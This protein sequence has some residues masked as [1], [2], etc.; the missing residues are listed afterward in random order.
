MVNRLRE[1]VDKLQQRRITLL[2]T[3]REQRDRVGRVEID[4][5]EA[6]L[7]PE[8]LN[9][10]AILRM[11]RQQ[12]RTDTWRNEPATD[13][14]RTTLATMLERR[15]M[16]R[17]LLDAP[18][19][20]GDA[21]RAIKAALDGQQPALTFP[22][23]E[24][25][26][27]FVVPA[28]NMDPEPAAASEQAAPGEDPRQAVIAAVVERATADAG[29][30]DAASAQSNTFDHYIGWAVK[31]S[32][33]H[34]LSA[35]A[36]LMDEGD[37]QLRTAAR[38]LLAD[39]ALWS[40]VPRQI[41]EEVWNTHRGGP[42]PDETAAQELAEAIID[43][44]E[45]G[46]V[47]P[48]EQAQLA[49]DLADELGQRDEPDRQT[50]AQEALDLANT[51]ETANWGELGRGAF[52][53]EHLLETADPTSHP[54]VA[55]ALVG[56]RS[57]SK[58]AQQIRQDFDRGF[59][60][61]RAEYLE[62]EMQR[63][64]AE[65]AADP[66]VVSMVRD[67]GFGALQLWADHGF[68][69]LVKRKFAD[70]PATSD[71]RAAA[72]TE[73]NA[74]FYYRR[75]YELAQQAVHH[76]P[77][78][79]DSPFATDVAQEQWRTWAAGRLEADPIISS[80]FGRPVSY[81]H[82][83]ALEQATARLVSDFLEQ[84]PDLVGAM[85]SVDTRWLTA[86][87]HQVIHTGF[88]EP[89]EH[90]VWRDTG[91]GSGWVIERPGKRRIQ[92]SWR[93]GQWELST[94]SGAGWIRYGTDY[95]AAQGAAEKI[96]GVDSHPAIRAIADAAQST[97]DEFA[98]RL[99]NALAGDEFIDAIARSDHMCEY[100]FNAVHNSLTGEAV[101]RALAGIA[102]DAPALLETAK[103]QGLDPRDFLYEDAVPRIIRAAR[104]EHTGTTERNLFS[105]EAVPDL[106][107]PTSHTMI[108]GD[109]D[110]AHV[111]IRLPIGDNG[112][113]LPDQDFGLPTAA[114]AITEARARLANA[115][116]PARAV[117][118]EQQRSS[119]AQAA[120]P[121]EPTS[122]EDVLAEEPG[123]QDTPTTDLSRDVEKPVE[124]MVGPVRN[125]DGSITWAI[126]KQDAVQTNGDEG[127]ARAEGATAAAREAT[128]RLEPRSEAAPVA[129][130]A[131]S[132]PHREGS[133]PQRS[134]APPAR[135]PDPDSPP[136][137]LPKVPQ[138][139]MGAPLSTWA[140]KRLIEV[141]RPDG[142]RV[143]VTAETLAQ[144][145]QPVA[146][147]AVRDIDTPPV[148]APTLIAPETIVAEPRAPAR[149]V[150]AVDFE[151]GT[152]VLVPASA[153]ARIEAN[154]DA[155]RVVKTLD[156]ERRNAT[157]D[158]QQILARWSGWGGAWQVFDKQKSEYD[159]QRAEL[160][161]LL[162]DK[163]F[164]A[165]RRSTVNAH[166]TDPALVDAMWDALRQAGLPEQARVLEPGCGAGH[167]IS[168]APQGVRMV[169]V[170]LDTMTSKI[171]HHLY[172]SQHVRNHGFE[173][174]F[175]AD[176]SFT[177]AIGNVPFGDIQPYDDKHNPNALS[178]HNYFIRKSLALTQP[179]GYVATITSKFTSDAQRT[180]AREQIAELGDFVG[181][182]RLPSK[183]FDRQAKTDVVTDLLI[184]R[185]REVGGEPTE[186]TKQW[187]KST[188]MKV[189]DGRIPI[190]DYF[191]AHPQNVL[192]TIRIGHGLHGSESLNVDADTSRPLVDQVR[193]RLSRITAEARAT[194]LGLTAPD[195]D[196]AAAVDL[197]RGGLF[198]AD[199]AAARVIPGTI[200]FNDVGSTFE[201]YEAGR[202]TEL[203]SKGKSRTA[204]WRALLGMGDTVLELVN[205][206][207]TATKFEQ[208]EELRERLNRQYDAYV[209][210][211][212][213]INR[214]KWTNHATRATDEQA[215]KRFPELERK[216]RAENGDTALDVDG[217]TIT[218][219][220]DGELP[221]EVVGE[222][223]EVAYIPAQAPYKKRSHLEGAIKY[224]PRLAMVRGIEH[225]NDD[226]HA[227]SKAAIFHDDISTSLA[228]ATS[229]QDIDEA[230][231]ISLDEAGSIDP[232]RMA[233]LLDTT[234]DD[235]LG[236]ARGKMYPAIESDDGWVPAAVFL[237]GNVRQKLA[238]ARVREAEN[239]ARYVDAVQDLSK[240]VPV[241]VDPSKI[242]LRPG[243]AWIGEDVYRQFLVQEFSLND[244]QLET[245]YSALTGSWNIRSHQQPMWLDEQYGYRDNWGMPE[246]DMS[247]IKLFAAMCNNKPLQCRKTPEELEA[248]PKP[249]FH[250]GRT[251]ELRDRA[252]RLEERF[253]QWLWSDPERTDR[254]TRKFN[255]TF[256]S[257]VRLEHSTEHKKF[258]GLNTEKYDP[259]PYQKQAVVRL[260]HDETVLLDHCVG[261][262]KTLSIAMSCMEMKRLGL[263]QQPW[264]V[265]PNHLVNQW[266]R[267]VL[268]AYP[269]ANVLVATDLTGKA[270][271]QRFMGQCAA[272]DWDVVIVP[273][274]KFFLMAVSPETQIDYIET[275]KT[276]LAI[277]LDNAKKAGRG[278]TVKEIEK[279]LE[280][281]EDQLEKLIKSKS[282]DTGITFEQT[283]C[284]FMFV[285]EAHMYKNLARASNSSDLA[286]IKA[287]ERASDMDM[288]I[289]YLRQRA[290]GRNREAGR[291]NAPARAAAFATG[292]PVSNSMSELWVMQK[293]LRPDLLDDLQ[294]GHIDAWA[295][296]FARQRTTVEMNVTGS[297]LRPVSR[298]AEYTNLPQLIALT[299]Q[300]RD[301]VVRDQ[302]PR[303][304][305]SLRDGTRT[306]VNFT[307]GREVRD[308]MHDLDERMQKTTRDA[309]HLDNA[310]KI[311]NDG[312]N[313]SLH[314]ALANLAEPDPSNDRVQQVVDQVW[315]I[316]VENA[317]MQ[318]PADEAG[319]DAEGVFQMVFCDRGT[320]KP[321]KSARAG[322]LYAMIRER[323]VERGMQPDEI[324]FIHDF[325]AAKD[326]QRLFADCRAGKVRVLIGSTE[327]MSTGVNAQRLLKA[328]HHM[329]CPYR[330]A[331]LEQR[332]GRIIRQGNVHEEVEILTYVAEQSFDA[333]MWQI[334][335]RKAHYIQQLKT[336][337]VPHSMEDIGGE[338]AM[339]AA[340]TKAAATGDPVYVEAVELESQVKRL[341]NE[342]R[343]VNQINHLNEYMIRTFERDLPIYRQQVEELRAIAGPINEWFDTDRERRKI[344]IGSET[345]VDGD[346]EKV[347]AAL[348]ATLQDRYTYMR[349]NKSEATETLFEVAGTPVYGTYHVQTGALRLHTDG[350]LTRYVEEKDALD[351]MASNKAGHGLMA[352]VRNMLKTVDGGL[353]HAERD[354][355]EMTSRLDALRA[356][357][358][359]EFTKGAELR[360]L[361]YDLVEM[362]ADINAR[363]NSPEA[364]R[365]FAEESDR[366]GRMGLYPGWSLDLNPT[367]GHADDRG[368]TRNGLIESVPMRM[369]S[370]ADRWIENEAA[371]AE[372]RKSDPWQ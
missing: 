210:T 209:G 314:P 266:H 198:T 311:S 335:E 37:P 297:Q 64:V 238:Q 195:V 82:D 105:V 262:G 323:L 68:R 217:E 219:P 28:R 365:R 289:N 227:V 49:I 141:E 164:A 223:W 122:R 310:L 65:V 357:P 62:P 22:S 33:S 172:P 177:A 303:K 207:R 188:P 291:P 29:L 23:G 316:H 94:N 167:F 92:I 247:G 243:A 318:T 190:N 57:N 1:S 4:L 309:M 235:V 80:F 163:E 274:S 230:I 130:P 6:G 99:V 156:E 76:A 48:T 181:G 108:V 101:D 349:M 100:E 279:A 121:D 138:S 168:H 136:A 43:R 257:F 115:P 336:G 42:S 119:T 112:W 107:M 331:D 11:G 60:A 91:G 179:G 59:S 367:V 160:H 8:T 202:W 283:G 294:M 231:A 149:D 196:F 293:Y 228:P 239:P 216:W 169:G 186:Q 83:A 191:Q 308:F 236:Q 47:T 142:S 7:D 175:A 369:Q 19:T 286:V 110:G 359:L 229:A 16:P 20:K 203:P 278:H 9:A 145:H 124:A 45:P 226:T 174:D 275:E 347:I 72:A 129:E 361:E 234:V 114:E 135:E 102:V 214:Y 54:Q 71:L 251:E 133:T 13:K 337:D 259:F 180:A 173:R 237:S 222:L 339:S 109:I 348:Q 333:T 208:R 53:P 287:A 329:D 79:V 292:T 355:L 162:S 215:T 371:R 131:P 194:G 66:D 250:K 362:K 97:R 139:E 192:G 273:E 116:S 254:L 305:P 284:D 134:A 21:D 206:S 322:N 342:E 50:I 24:V 244:E 352:R 35:L 127:E 77:A 151:L 211:Y 31:E 285:D 201:Q 126:P 319:P 212:G 30:N 350:G 90:P 153:R 341:V 253:T 34:A 55:A 93:M 3:Y 118:D 137:E 295:Q 75:P 372:S 277:G 298:M 84:R 147:A 165:A 260:L 282:A 2:D 36:D 52:D 261:A 344:T 146:A 327:T 324:A 340:Q 152:A 159:A 125:P 281:R 288:K 86:D 356:E 106:H 40:E 366:R 5:R 73:L 328:L 204:E 232:R 321:G 182:V 271:R 103:Q 326:K 218:E 301:V 81:P 265:V 360:R 85:R 353:M 255:D 17:E 199:N 41:A 338:M 269:G 280:R 144:Y 143:R 334:V 315:R 200:R 242:G 306:I 123:E 264:I 363:E 246:A 224:D 302:I 241:D 317:D 25:Q 161:G 187:I 58:V 267:E 252:E 78:G 258:P 304:L 185:R 158:E 171:A 111:K 240:V 370:H 157:P 63:V 225:Y 330:P 354:L 343:S 345:V 351:A 178:I 61:A 88:S 189:G 10:R 26:R 312:R 170:E 38:I 12:A 70:M 128:R 233:E 96:A 140:S 104:A 166:Y 221:D 155:I 32:K 270:D 205:A 368:L 44:R 307:L 56:I 213:P 89:Q 299:D 358:P 276:A 332:E 290:I 176:A 268:D 320:P 74:E 183:A 249:A 150:P 132:E 67:T 248:N 313:A 300:F 245:E 117:A 39:E 193:D 95:R 27:P 113:R 46:P 18:L 98:R 325:P 364:I 256:N 346:S 296:N 87:V 272:G 51:A 184:F 14:Q 15:G 197:D 220:Y 154:I 120:D 148:E 263:V 69:S